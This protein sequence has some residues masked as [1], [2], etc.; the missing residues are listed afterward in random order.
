MHGQMEGQQEKDQH[1]LVQ[2]K[3][4]STLSQIAASWVTV[5]AFIYAVV[6][7]VIEYNGHKRSGR[8]KQSMKLIKKYYGKTYRA[9]RGRLSY[10]KY[11]KDFVEAK[12]IKDKN[13]RLRRVSKL[14]ETFFAENEIYIFEFI[15]FFNQIAICVKADMCERETVLKFIGDPGAT[16]FENYASFI[17]KFRRGNRDPDYAQEAV[18]LFLPKFAALLDLK[19]KR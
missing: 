6:A 8:V 15:D 7:G 16:F 18:R 12:S 10:Y 5:I 19:S 3:R 2:L 1:E 9:H 11:R 14:R 13:E 4:K 17:L